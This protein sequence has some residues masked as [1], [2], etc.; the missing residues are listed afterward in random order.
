MNDNHRTPDD[1]DLDDELD[2]DA[3]P[4]VVER[5][6]HTL[7]AVAAATPVTDRRAALLTAVD[8]LPTPVP[9]EEDPAMHLDATT[10]AT[11]PIWRRPLVLAAAAALVVAVVG[12]ALVAG[13]DQAVELDPAVPDDVPVTG[14]YL[15]PEGWEITEVRT[16]FLDVGESGACPCRY[17]AAAGEGQDPPAITA[18]ESVDGGV[19]VETGFDVEVDVD[20]RPGLSADVGGVTLSMPALQVS[21]GG[22]QLVLVGARV[23]LESLVLVADAWLDG[24]EAGEG[25]VPAD[26]PLPEGLVPG[27]VIESPALQSV[28]VVDVAV[29]EPATGRQTYYQLVPA[30]AWYQS[31]LL[32][33]DAIA[34]RAG[35]FQATT[36]VGDTPLVGLIGGPV[37]LVVG[38]SFFAEEGSEMS[39]QE[40]SDF[41]GG[42]RQVPVSDWRDALAAAEVPP[43]VLEAETLLGPP[44]VDS[45]VDG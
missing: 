33:P 23:D 27:R 21:S 13:R 2:L 17:W 14:W 44:L 18:Y 26:L 31:L 45:P 25:L 29:T 32:G 19:E 5:L 40:L 34:F 37:D 43:A 41:L 42:L 1:D 28:H 6:R 10:D 7:Q 22:R 38:P 15:P 9:S 35:A 24:L 30:G 4:A 39:A 8:A 11:R 12:G 16:D 36:T 3:D 20:G